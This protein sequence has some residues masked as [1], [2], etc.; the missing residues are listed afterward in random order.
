ME[1]FEITPASQNKRAWKRG[2]YGICG[3]D[4][5]GETWFNP[6]VLGSMGIIMALTG[7]AQCQVHEI[8]G[9]RC[10]LIPVA[11]AKTAFP[12]FADDLDVLDSRIRRL[13]AGQPLEQYN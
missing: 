7:G 11:W 1:I 12:T 5:A 2:A 13:A 3:L 10:A 6:S 8:D 4:A 9:R